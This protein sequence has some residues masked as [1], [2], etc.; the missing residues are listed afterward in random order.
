MVGKF[1][2]TD[3]GES[4]GRLGQDKENW[5]GARDREE[6]GDVDVW[7]TPKE[8]GFGGSGFFHERERSRSDVR[9]Y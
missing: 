9:G 7:A 8:E 1:G 4:R 5:G 3:S 6:E 2:V